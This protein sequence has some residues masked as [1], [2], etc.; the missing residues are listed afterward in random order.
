VTDRTRNQDF[1]RAGLARVEEYVRADGKTR[2]RI[3]TRD[4]HVCSTSTR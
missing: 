1:L 4:E 2:K 3:I